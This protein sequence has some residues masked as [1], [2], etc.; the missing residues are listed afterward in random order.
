MKE[1]V[2]EDKIK[3][4]TPEEKEQVIK[5]IDEILSKKSIDS[6][7]RKLTFEWAGGLAD[8]KDQ[9]TSVELQKQINEWRIEKSL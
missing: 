5:F 7:N 9:Y 6:S 2:L 4:L 3:Q 1:S 8:L